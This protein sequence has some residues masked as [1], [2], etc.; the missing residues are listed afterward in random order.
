MDSEIFRWL[1]SP[2]S[3][4]GYIEGV[5]ADGTRQTNAPYT[6][7]YNATTSNR[8]AFGPASDM[9]SLLV[10][11]SGSDEPAWTLCRFIWAVWLGWRQSGFV[12]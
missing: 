12:E 6:P 4:G 8:V 11:L 5:R 10:A 2:I 9:K 3:S 7:G 1:R